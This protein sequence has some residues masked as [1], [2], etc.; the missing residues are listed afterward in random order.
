MARIDMS[1]ELEQARRQKES[2]EQEMTNDIVTPF[3]VELNIN[4]CQGSAPFYLS[5]AS[6][7]LINPLTIKSQYLHFEDKTYRLEIF[8]NRT[9]LLDIQL[10]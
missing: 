7:T 3:S 10:H 9:I 6:A 2:P 4:L 1:H 8:K 5:S